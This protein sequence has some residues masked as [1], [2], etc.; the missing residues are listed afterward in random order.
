MI[1][2]RRS[3]PLRVD[4]D[5]SARR[6][7]SALLVRLFAPSFPPNIGV[8]E[9]G[10][11]HLG[12]LAFA[13]SHFWVAAVRASAMRRTVSIESH[14]PNLRA[15]DAL[16]LPRKHTSSSSSRSDCG[17]MSGRKLND[18]GA[19]RPLATV[20]T[21]P[22]HKR[23]AFRVLGCIHAGTKKPRASMAGGRGKE[24]HLG[25]GAIN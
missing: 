19:N 7:S 1:E 8:G 20:K 23:G 15:S 10:S 17:D 11:G 24:A 13:F 16:S 25:R 4:S 14:Q 22:H 6:S 2:G 9:I 3:L 18:S 12:M 5:D 21:R